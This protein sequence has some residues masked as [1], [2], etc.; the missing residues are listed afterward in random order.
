LKERDTEIEKAEAS[1]L[2]REKDAMDHG[3]S[4]LLHS[5]LSFPVSCV[6]LSVFTAHVSRFTFLFDSNCFFCFNSNLR[7]HPPFSIPLFIFHLFFYVC[8]EEGLKAK[9][10][11]AS[12]EVKRLTGLLEA[13][14]MEGKKMLDLIL[15]EQRGEHEGLIAEKDR[16][17]AEKHAQLQELEAGSSA[18]EKEFAAT[19]AQQR[20]QHE[21]GG[22]QKD[23]ELAEV[24]VYHPIC[25]FRP[26]TYPSSHPTHHLHI[27]SH[28]GPQYHGPAIPRAL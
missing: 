24:A 5:L 18:R 12:Q 19:T 9:M 10:F 27:T 14:E 26:V 11:S 6:L 25:H 17:L 8:A 4:L 21:D 13:K 2:A 20:Q 15:K 16:E 7:L 28:P 3:P 22:N 1:R 23:Q